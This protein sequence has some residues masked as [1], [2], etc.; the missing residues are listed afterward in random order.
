ME[1]SIN[2]D[3]MLV[4]EAADYMRVSAWTIRR[5]MKLEGL[6]YFRIKE[7]GRVFISRTDLIGF[8]EYYRHP[9]SGATRAKMIKLLRNRKRRP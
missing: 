6:P 2:G 7:R 4:A 5:W 3:I 8:M 9:P 1:E